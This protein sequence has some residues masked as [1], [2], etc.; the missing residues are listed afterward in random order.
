MRITFEIVEA[1]LR[2]VAILLESLTALDQVW[3]HDH[4]LTPSLYESGV[5]FVPEDGTEVW[6]TIPIVL[7]RGWGNCD[8]LAAWRA[9][10]LRQRGRTN[11][12]AFPI[13]STLDPNLIHC[14]VSVDGTLATIE[15]PSH[16]LG[17]PPVPPVD[18]APALERSRQ[19][20]L[21]SCR[22]WHLPR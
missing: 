11:A 8:M 10:E 14:L 18:L 21:R 2:S 13:R 20:L 12:V 15:D 19:W 16:V 6:P 5:R 7:A 9:A 17:A 1:D 4:P 3:L 22:S